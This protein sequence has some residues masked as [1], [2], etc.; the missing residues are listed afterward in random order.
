[1][2]TKINHLFFNPIDTARFFA[3]FFLAPIRIST[4]F[5]KDVH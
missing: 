1:M 4:V 5:H 3:G 2:R